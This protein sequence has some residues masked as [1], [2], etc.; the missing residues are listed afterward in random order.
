VRRPSIV[1]R[2]TL[3]VA[4]ALVAVPGVAGSKGL[5]LPS[6]VDANLFRGVEI[7]SLARGTETTKY[8]LDPAQRSRSALDPTAPIVEP[9]EPRG[10]PTRAS[11]SVPE[12]RVIAVRIPPPT[13]PPPAR[14]TPTKKAPTG[15]ST[16]GGGEDTEADTGGSW[17]YDAHVSWYGPGF[18]GNRTACGQRYTE[19]IMGVAHKTLPCGTRVS[20]KYGG[21]VITVP[22]IDRGP[23]IAGRNWDLSAAA[24]RALRHCFTGP[25]YWRFP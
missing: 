3:I 2:V 16:S 25:L 6:A 18:Y 5:A 21:R 23:Y 1:A 9:A 20:F 17:R 14:E 24:C 11:V 10:V 7:A 8:F 15:G 19:T 12:A 4:L 22:V 13:P